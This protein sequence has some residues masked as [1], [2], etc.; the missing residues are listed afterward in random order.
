MLKGIDSGER[1]ATPHSSLTTTLGGLVGFLTT[2]RVTFRVRV[3]VF[4]E[5]DC[6]LDP[7]VLLVVVELGEVFDEELVPEETEP[8][9]TTLP[10]VFD[11]L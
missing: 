10:L 4:G 9:S 5:E 6:V 7:D 3:V 11:E 8:L 1:S 2:L